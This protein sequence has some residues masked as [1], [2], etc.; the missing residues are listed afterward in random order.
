MEDVI[1]FKCVMDDRIKFYKIYKELPPDTPEVFR[2]L[3]S[4]VRYD[5]L[6]IRLGECG[7]LDRLNFSADFKESTELESEKL[8]FTIKCEN[9]KY[10]S[11]EEY[12]EA[13]VLMNRVQNA[14][15]D[16]FEKLKGE[17][18]EN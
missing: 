17:G 6:T 1:L 5:V 3:K 18:N 4:A 7:W 12:Q 10:C 14:F 15:M 9:G 13:Y 2:K 16:V 8:A 11:P